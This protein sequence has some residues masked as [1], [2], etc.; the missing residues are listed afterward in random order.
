M[1]TER[2]SAIR[3]A[4][5]HRIAFAQHMQNKAASESS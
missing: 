5:E 4:D 2:E 1:R 3:A